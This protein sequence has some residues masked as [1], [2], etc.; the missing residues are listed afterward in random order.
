[1][2]KLLV[3]ARVSPNDLAVIGFHGQTVAHRP[4]RGWTW[5]IGD[6]AAMAKALGVPVV[7]D[8]RA[9]DVAAGGQGAPLIPVYHRALRAGLE[10][11]VAVL[12]L[13]GVGNLTWIGADGDAGRL[14]HRPGQCADRRLDAGRDRPRATTRTARFAATGRVDEAVLTAMLDNAVLRPA[15]AQIARPRRFHDPAGA[16][17]CPR[18]TARRR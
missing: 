17:A 9:A 5:Q 3:E 10:K 1:M 18:R 12:N 6:G 11:P 7:S 13:G 14:R 8:F 2:R 4:D 15:A 16:R